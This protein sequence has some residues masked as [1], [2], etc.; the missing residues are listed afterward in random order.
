MK[1]A[2][3]IDL[4]IEIPLAF[5]EGRTNG[6]CDPVQVVFI[7][8]TNHQ[9]VH[10][11]VCI[12]PRRPVR[13]VLELLNAGQSLRMHV[14]D[15]RKALLHEDAEFLR[16]DPAGPGAE[17]H[18]QVDPGALRQLGDGLDHITHIILA[19]LPPRNGGDR[20]AHPGEKQ[21]EIIVDLRHGT[22]GRTGRT[23]DHLLLNGDGRTQPMYM[24]HIGFIHAH[25][26]LPGIG[27]EAFS[28]P[29]LPFC[30]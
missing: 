25:Q 12:L 29:P 18:Q 14:V 8:G 2:Q 26:E 1:E 6:V 17:W 28:I 20:T 3:L 23:G 21:P 24:I 30:V 15:P 5:I 11:H 4:E 10:Q 22:D 19:D 13:H 9:P 7:K 27:T 16:R